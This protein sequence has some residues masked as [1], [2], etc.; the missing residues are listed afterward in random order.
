MGWRM[1]VS[2]AQSE[3]MGL[4]SWSR[5]GTGSS[6]RTGGNGAESLPDSK[7]GKAGG[8]G[9]E[10]GAMGPGARGDHN[11]AASEAEAGKSAPPVVWPPPGG[12]DMRKRC[13]A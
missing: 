8:T 4:M 7:A 9:I 3:G 2:S 13:E 1:L 6:N 10:P 11:G 5:A 12:Y